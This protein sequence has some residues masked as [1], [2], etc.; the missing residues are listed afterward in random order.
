MLRPVIQAVQMF[1]K[2]ATG[3]DRQD[4]QHLS[5]HLLALQ[6]AYD[7]L[8]QQHSELSQ[9]HDGLTHKYEHLQKQHTQ[10]ESSHSKLHTD[11]SDLVQRLH[12]KEKE[13]NGFVNVADSET[14]A[15]TREKEALA[16]KLKQS[17]DN[18]NKLSDD[19]NILA[20]QVAVLEAELNR[21]SYQQ[22]GESYAE[23]YTTS[24]HISDGLIPR[25][26]GQKVALNALEAQASSVDLS[27]ISLALIGGHETTYREVKKE[28][29]QYGLKRCV[30]IPPH[31]VMSSDRNQIKEKISHC[32]LIITI[33]S[34]VDHPVAKCVKSL[35]DTKVLAGECIRV[36]SHG[37]SSL[38]REVLKYFKSPLQYSQQPQ[39]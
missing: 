24:D 8:Q 18:N 34:Y 12:N 3:K 5:E 35:R 31:S 13:I 28:L 17:E 29:S 1:L 14:K 19:K 38:V 26:D 23:S 2:G 27:D 36:S 33:T 32:D 39:L 15:L 21:L 20:G 6:V 25:S 10:L 30:H 4:K 16:L 22:R 37:K 11:C 7:N 9:Q